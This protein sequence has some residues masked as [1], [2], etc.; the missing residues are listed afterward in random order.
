MSRSLS[1]EELIE[2]FISVREQTLKICSPLEKEDCSVQP[3]AEVSPPKWHLG[4]TTWFFE[5]MILESFSESFNR[6][7][8]SF[9]VIFNSYYKS[10]GKHWNQCDRGHLSGP[11]VDQVQ[12]YRKYV[13][14]ALLMFLKGDVSSEVLCLLEVGIHHEQ[15]HQELL[16]MDIKYILGTNP[17]LPA[18]S[19]DQFRVSSRMN[20]GWKSFQE[21]VFE[22]GHAGADFAYDNES[23]RHKVYLQSFEIS[24]V[25]VTNGDYLAF[26]KAGGYSEPR[27]WL[28]K[29]WDWLNEKKVTSPLYWFQKEGA[30][31][32][33]GLNGSHELDLNAPVS[34]VSYFEADAFARWSGCRLPTEQESEVFLSEFPESEW[35]SQNW[36]WTQSH[37]S[38][39]PGYKCFE[40]ALGEYNGKFMCSQ[41]VLRG[42]CAMTPAKHYRHSYRNFY[43]PHQRWMFSGIRLAKDL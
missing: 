24:D 10:V 40:G 23:P 3:C 30:W 42:G 37:Y 41:F 13:N 25:D 22:V 16:W 21:G 6:F 27:Y 18:Y 12:S 34:H 33:Y 43:E 26:M 19:K 20:S 31:Y 38:P 7:D 35:V 9:H 14:E 39:Y 15:Q 28:S 29:G 1:K 17:A 5:K 8:E 4:H 32:E 2:S 11:T 36:W